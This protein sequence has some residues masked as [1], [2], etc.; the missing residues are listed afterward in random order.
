[1]RPSK[2]LK[3]AKARADKYF[4]L[5]IRE[6]DKNKVCVTCGKRTSEKDCG[7]FISRRFE[8]TRYD[9]KNSHGQCLKCNRFEYGNQF[10][11]G[12]M[13][14]FVYGEGTADKLL[15][16]SKMFC[17][18]DRF[19]YDIIAEEYKNKYEEIKTRQV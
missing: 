9:E 8:S 18:R 4:S 1:M 2:T 13:I 14:D 11:Y 6:R 16:K 17:K 12:Q 10:Q 5:Y 3:A 19:D 7:H 15:Q